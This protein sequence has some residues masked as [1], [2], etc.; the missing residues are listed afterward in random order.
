MNTVNDTLWKP[1]AED[2]NSSRLHKYRQWLKENHYPETKDYESLWQWSVDQP[3]VFWET[4]ISFFNVTLHTPYTRVL[5]GGAMPDMIWFDGATLNYAEQIQKGMAGQ[6]TAI[7]FAS[8]R[9]DRRSI[10]VDDMWREVSKVRAYY[11]AHG[12]KTGDRIAGFLPNIPE[13]TFAFLAAASLGAVWSCCSPD[14]GISSVVDR[15]AQIEPVLFITADGYYYNGKTFSRTEEI[16]SIIELLPTLRNTLLI[17]Y[18]GASYTIA[19]ENITVYSSLKEGSEGI[20]AFV[21]VSFNHPLWILFSSGTTGAPKAIT[22]SHGGCLLEHLKYLAFH[23]DVH[24]GEKFFWYTTTGWM[25]WNFLQGAM[26]LGAT[27]VI[28]DGSPSYP[29]LSGL[30]K[31]AEEFQ[32]HHFGTSAPFIVACMKERRKP[33]EEQQLGIIRSIGSTG[34]PL[35]PE[36]FDWVY[37]SVHSRIWLCSMSGGTD[38]CTAFVGGVIE[39]NVVRGEI[40]ARALGCSLYAFD[41]KKQPVIDS[42][43]EMV[44]TKPMPSM[45]IYFWHDPG[46]KRYKASYFE[47][48]PGVWRHGDWVKITKGG[49]VVIYGRSDATLNR[50][51]IRIGTA[52]IYRVLNEIPEIEDSLIVNLELEGGR[53]YMPLFVKLRHGFFLDEDLKKRIAFLLKTKCTPRHVPD[54]VI[55]VHDI[56]YTI[57]GK[58]MEAPVKKILMGMK[59]DDSLNRDAMRNPDSLEFFTKWVVPI[60]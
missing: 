53:H 46:K 25:M 20:P 2:I 35:P 23:N 6:Q 16:S 55:L 31:L 45:P 54:D 8:E 3:E 17:E 51:G 57:S 47:D 37:E 4:I 27:I 39:K 38:V 34:S 15:F 30:W 50:H 32:I 28:Y 40:Q 18:T 48:I 44:I 60:E 21:P 7:L 12:V 33:G 19:N 11:L 24:K 10:S 26:L 1:S 58:K 13:A 49:G 36:A 9:G 52:E 43:G 14:F 42:L 22:H 56:P 59:V 5:S 41:E 29:D